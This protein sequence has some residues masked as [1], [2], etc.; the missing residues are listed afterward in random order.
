MTLWEEG[1]LCSRYHRNLFIPKNIIK[2]TIA[3][4]D[5]RKAEETEQ[6]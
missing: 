6:V 5:E 4:I 2:Q 1:I 3:C